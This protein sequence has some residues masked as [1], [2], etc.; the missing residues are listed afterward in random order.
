M[1]EENLTEAE[2]TTVESVETQDEAVSLSE[3]IQRLAEESE[4]FEETVEGEETQSYTPDY[5]YKVKDEERSFDER[6]HNIVKSKD[7]EEYLR[8][9]YTRADGLDSVKSRLES[10]E[11]AYKRI[12]SHAQE[13]TN[14]YANLMKY[15]D[16]GDVRNLQKALGITDDFVVNWGLSLAE[17]EQLPDEQRELVR[18]NRELQEQLAEKDY[19]LK[20]SQ[21]QDDERSIQ[22][23]IHELEG[24]M[25]SEEFAPLVD[26]MGKNGLSFV[27]TVTMIGSHEFQTTGKEPTI[28]DVCDR[29]RGKYE[30]L[31]TQAQTQEAVG[32]PAQQTNQTVVVREKTIPSVGGA[33]TNAVETP[34][35]SISDL[36]KLA[37]NM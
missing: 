9:L 12:Y 3:K 6:F 27:D 34:V 23:D 15:R 10:R 7:D 33:N 17:E 11:D 2:E 35:R 5:T 28:R 24:Y 31:V 29:V 26:A 1:S 4:T 32:Q 18:M 19:M 21:V 16:S 22:E 8:D 14:G 30:F 36:K 13:L 25:K 20:T 37:A